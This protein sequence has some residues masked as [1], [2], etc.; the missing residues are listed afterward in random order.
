[1]NTI[2]SYLREDGGDQGGDD[3]RRL[4]DEDAEE[5]A[6]EQAEDSVKNI[7]VNCGNVFSAFGVDLS[8]MDMSAYNGQG[9]GQYNGAYNNGNYNYYADA[10]DYYAN[11]NANNNNNNNNNGEDEDNGEDEFQQA[12]RDLTIHIRLEKVLNTDEFRFEEDGNYDEIRNQILEELGLDEEDLSDSDINSIKL[13]LAVRGGALEEYLKANA[14]YGSEVNDWD[15]MLQGFFEEQGIEDMDLKDIDTYLAAYIYN[16]E[17]ELEEYGCQQAMLNQF[18]TNGAKEYGYIEDSNFIV[19]F[20]NAALP[21][22]DIAGIVIG[23][24]AAVGIIG[25][26]S[27]RRGKKIGKNAEKSF[28]EVLADSRNEPLTAYTAAAV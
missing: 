25:F 24:L 8:N 11:A 18:G 17:Y 6:E 9:N 5:D 15:T 3:G 27:Y 21:Y 19:D 1:M 13:K 2:S 12:L 14:A 4:E 10:N 7:L 26:F 23:V 16:T 28:E 22:G 20:F